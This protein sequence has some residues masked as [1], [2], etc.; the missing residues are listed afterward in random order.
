MPEGRV[1]IGQLNL[2]SKPGW[3]RDPLKRRDK[4]FEFSFIRFLVDTIDMANL[5][6]ADIQADF[7]PF[8]EL[9]DRTLEYAK[10]QSIFVFL[11]RSHAGLLRP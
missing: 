7:T 8:T 2:N 6:F 4:F 5:I 10:G 3:Q 9:L 11:T 1:P